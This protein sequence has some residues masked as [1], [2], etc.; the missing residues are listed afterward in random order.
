VI[1]SKILEFVFDENLKEGYVKTK[2]SVYKL[3]N[4]WENNNG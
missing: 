3:E 1:T 2:N 4:R